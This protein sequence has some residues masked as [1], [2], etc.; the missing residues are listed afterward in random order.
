MRVVVD[1][2]GEWPGLEPM[3]DFGTERRVLLLVGSSAE[4]EVTSPN[5]PAEFGADPDGV[6]DE[7]IDDISLKNAIFP[8]FIFA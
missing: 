4:Q 5:T 3:T 1:R 2:D 7:N 8:L 6:K